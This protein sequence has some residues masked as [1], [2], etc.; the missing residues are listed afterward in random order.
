MPPHNG[1]G[2]GADEVPI[3]DTGSDR[4]SRQRSFGASWGNLIALLLALGLLASFLLV[5]TVP[6]PPPPRR[7]PGGHAAAASTSVPATAVPTPQG[8]RVVGP[9][10][11]A[12]M[13]VV[14]GRVA[15]YADQV[16]SIHA[17][18]RT[19]SIVVASWTSFACPSGSPLPLKRGEN[20]IVYLLAQTNGALMARSVCRP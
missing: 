12:A 2:D 3:V 13:Y 20:V 16:L 7:P 9:S 11:R 6:D 10:G 18:Q 15:G 1:L 17:A 4:P 19:Y 8:R 14:R 5:A